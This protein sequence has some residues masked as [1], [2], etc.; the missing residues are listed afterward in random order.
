MS[1]IL[2]VINPFYVFK[3]GDCLNLSEDGT[4]YIGSKEESFEHSGDDGQVFSSSC[5]NTF[6]IS[7][8]YA[9]D[10]IKNGYLKETANENTQFVNVFDEIDRL[11]V[12]YE[13][14]LKNI[15]KG[16]ENVPACIKVEKTTVLQNLIKVLTH[17]K[18]LKK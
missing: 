15:D 17:L 2:Q 4:K 10:L 16:A 12:T 11:L 5:K 6:T 18:N 9:E 1:K 7:S 3:S 14:D 13:E 8:N